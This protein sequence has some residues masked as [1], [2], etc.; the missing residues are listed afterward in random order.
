ML[1]GLF[2]LTAIVPCLDSFADKRLEVWEVNEARHMLDTW[3]Q[4]LAE[5]CLLPWIS[6]YYISSIAS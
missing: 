3:I 4:A 1:A 6:G 5:P 2:E